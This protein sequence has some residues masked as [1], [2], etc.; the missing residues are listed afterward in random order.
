M[1]TPSQSVSIVSGDT[2]NLFIDRYAKAFGRRHSFVLKATGLNSAEVSS[3]GSYVKGAGG[4]VW[5]DYGS[6][7]LHLLGHR[8]SKIVKAA[9]D[10]LNN[11]GLSTKILP[12][13][14]S[15]DCAEKLIRAVGSCADKVI[16]TN[17][18]SEA[19]EC[20]IRLASLNS[21]YLSF[22]ALEYAYHGRTLGAAAL[23]DSIYRAPVAEKSIDVLR[24]PRNDPQKTYDLITNAKLAAVFVELTQG[25]GGIYSLSHSMVN[26]IS[27][28][29]QETGALIVV[30]E[31][32]TGLGRVGRNFAFNDYDILPDIV[33][34]GKTLGGG[35]LPVS[36]TAFN[37]KKLGEKVSDMGLHSS[38]FAGGSLA[39]AVA[40]EVVE[41]IDDTN[42]RDTVIKI[43]QTVI[44]SISSISADFDFVINVRGRGCMIGV[45]FDSPQTCGAV[46]LELAKQGVLVSFCLVSPSV[47][48]IYPSISFTQ[49]E[50]RK[51]EKA[52]A[53]ALHSRL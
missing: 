41:I 11:M 15:V 40:G 19:I 52:F 47:M 33:V 6:Y 30:D 20:A 22:G 46:I 51:F 4:K 49:N 10:M 32:Q 43:G 53:H 9:R 21:K 25:E 5:L 18:G 50:L 2:A 28:A 14:A 29:C 31:I 17:S 7:G 42:F 8:N 44:Q 27:K 13:N 16:Y 37:S 38:S 39:M 48:R 36:A 35:L 24:L 45:E 1:K 34:I 12:N 3:E 26:A 23:T